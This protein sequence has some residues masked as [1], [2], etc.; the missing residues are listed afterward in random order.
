MQNTKKG[1]RGQIQILEVF[2]YGFV[3]VAIAALTLMVVVFIGGTLNASLAST[4]AWTIWGNIVT[5]ITNFTGQLG[6]VGTVA[7]VLM[8]LGLFLG[9]GYLG[10]RAVRP[11]GGS[12]M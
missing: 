7:G 6:T 10:Y 5:S 3:G 9:L 11:G 12:G 1:M 2:V 4:G 8:I